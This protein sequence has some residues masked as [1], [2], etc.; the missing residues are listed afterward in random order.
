MRCNDVKNAELL[1][2][3]AGQL[4]RWAAES[5]GGGWSTHQIVNIL[6]RVME[7]IIFLYIAG[8]L[9]G[10]GVELERN[11][12]EEVSTVIIWIGCLLI[13]PIAIGRALSRR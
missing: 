2:E 4:E 6:E 11:T 10:V 1:K 7:I 13:W 3:V 8:W 5:L 12:A 9:V